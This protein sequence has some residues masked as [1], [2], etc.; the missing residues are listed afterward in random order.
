MLLLLRPQSH[1]E[2]ARPKQCMFVMQWFCMHCML[3]YRICVKEK[4]SPRLA[5]VMQPCSVRP[6]RRRR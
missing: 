4:A 2:A 5:P 3:I 6:H 1:G